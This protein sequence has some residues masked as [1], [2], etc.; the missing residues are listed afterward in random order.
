[1]KGVLVVHLVQVLP[2]QYKQNT[3]PALS[4]FGGGNLVL[5]QQQKEFWR[6]MVLKAKVVTKSEAWRDAEQDEFDLASPSCQESRYTTN[7]TGSTN[8]SGSTN[9]TGFTNVIGFTD[10]TG[11]LEGFRRRSL[12]L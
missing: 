6:S 10:V 11:L 4:K 5:C 12:R 3:L 2:V 1:M 9:V 7:V 8:V